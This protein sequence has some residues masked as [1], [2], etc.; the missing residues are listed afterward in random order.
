MAVRI[1]SQRFVFD[2]CKGGKNVPE[3]SRKPSQS[4]N[5]MPVIQFITMQGMQNLARDPV[6]SFAG[7]AKTSLR[8][9]S[10]FC[11]GCKTIPEIRFRTLQGM[12]NLALNSVWTFARYAKP[13]PR[14]RAG[15][16]PVGDE[17]YPT[18]LFAS[19]ICIRSSRRSY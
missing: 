14:F 17:F 15:F 11:W 6:W 13:S 2:Q 8:F 9:S 10:D 3:I 4:R 1:T 16:T 18:G 5:Y 12:Q 7:V 19:K